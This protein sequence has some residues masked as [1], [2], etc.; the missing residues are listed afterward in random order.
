[1]MKKLIH[2]EIFLALMGL[3]FVL[4]IIWNRFIRVR[5]PKDIPLTLTDFKF[6]ILSF[7][8]L[9]FCLSLFLLVKEYL[10]PSKSLSNN[11]INKF[12][13]E[14]LRTFDR[15]I[16]DINFIWIKS[17]IIHLKIIFYAHR[18]VN[19]SKYIYLVFQLPKI[20]IPFFLLIDI[21]YFCKIEIFYKLIPFLIIPLLYRYLYHS[22]HFF[23]SV[24]KHYINEILKV[25][26]YEEAE[27]ENE[28]LYY[29]IEEDPIHYL[30]Q[31]TTLERLGVRPSKDMFHLTICDNYIEKNPYEDF[32]KIFNNAQVE[33]TLLSNLYEI[34]YKANDLK[35][36]YNSLINMV[37]ISMYSICWI[38]VLI[39]GYY[40]L[41]E[42]F[43]TFLNCIRNNID[44]FS[45]LVM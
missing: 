6:I 35:V 8:C 29:I 32:S 7:T 1:M 18:Y 21:F 45:G 13:T 39:T 27:G 42:D 24:R 2:K 11:I 10:Y 40:V 16:K 34:L 33:L 19:Y 41:S 23:Y 36:T 25:R 26:I 12:I 31:E 17:E 20:I 44:P 38:Y 22:L 3:L 14:S 37:M 28:P 5:L 4:F 43:L 30:I 9:I 15:K